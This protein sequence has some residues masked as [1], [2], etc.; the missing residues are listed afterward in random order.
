MPFDLALTKAGVDVLQDVLFVFTAADAVVEMPPNQGLQPRRKP[1]PDEPSGLVAL[2][3][4]RRTQVLNAQGDRTHRAHTG[5]QSPEKNTP[6][7]ASGY[8][9][10]AELAASMLFVRNVIVID[11]A[12]IPAEKCEMNQNVRPPAMAVSGQSPRID[13]VRD[14]EPHETRPHRPR[15]R[16]TDEA[17][18]FAFGH[19]AL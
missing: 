9:R 16:L 5:P 1:F 15:R 11:I 2:A 14:V 3:A 18:C 6:E 13:D 10:S 17:D 8:R 4:I 12:V 7:L 19:K